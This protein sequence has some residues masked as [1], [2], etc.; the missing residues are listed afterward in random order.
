MIELLRTDANHDDFVALVK[1]LDEE[2]AARD[3]DMHAYYHQFNQI[4]F[5][6]VAYSAAMPVGCGAIKQFEGESMEVK[7][8]FIL[9]EYR[10]QGIATKVLDELEKWAR[11]LNYKR[12]ILETGKNQPEA[13]Q[14]YKKSGYQSIP[15]YGQYV[16]IENSVCFEK[17]LK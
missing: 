8:M 6:I 14:L 3:G 5:A 4:K 16:G 11:E 2:L 17:I 15:N 7:R 13:I 1:L 10:G 12:C 9:P